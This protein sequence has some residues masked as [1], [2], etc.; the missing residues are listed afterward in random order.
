MSIDEPLHSLPIR[1][2]PEIRQRDSPLRRR[3]EQELG[4]A[5]PDDYVEFVSHHNGTEGH[6]G[7]ELLQLLRFEELP[8]YRKASAY[9]E[10]LPSLIPFGTNGSGELF[11]FDVRTFPMTIVA[12]QNPSIDVDEAI[13]LGHSFGEFLGRLNRTG[14][15]GDDR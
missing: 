10:L 3:I 4:V 8:S 12:M 6:V 7:G 1:E 5:L 15:L 11:A 14:I 13:V 2:L 9:E